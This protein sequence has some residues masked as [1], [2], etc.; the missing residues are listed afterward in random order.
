MAIIP[1]I[2]LASQGVLVLVAG[3]YGLARP[4]EFMAEMGDLAVESDQVVHAMRYV[5]V[6]WQLQY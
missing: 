5:R 3:I 4:A 1:A 6:A 2:T